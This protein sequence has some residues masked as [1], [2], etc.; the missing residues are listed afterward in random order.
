[1]FAECRKNLWRS[2]KEVLSID[3]VDP[4]SRTFGSQQGRMNELMSINALRLTARSARI[5]F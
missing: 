3:D 2:A 4:V 1:V 5:D